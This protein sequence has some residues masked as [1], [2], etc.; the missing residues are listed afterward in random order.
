MD[1][2]ERVNI[3]VN[4]VG[5]HQKANVDDWHPFDVKGTDKFLTIYNNLLSGFYGDVI[6]TFDG[7]HY[8]QVKPSVTDTG[9]PTMFIWKDGIQTNK[10]LKQQLLTH[11]HS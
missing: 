6:S 3:A 7:E 9:N 11:L 10:V 2:Q 4:F 1:N 8:C 5:L